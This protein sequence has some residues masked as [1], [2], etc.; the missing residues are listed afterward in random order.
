MFHVGKHRIAAVVSDWSDDY[1]TCG[2]E[3]PAAEG[4]VIINLE[5]D[6]LFLF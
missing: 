6:C 4:G 1:V 3:N 2:N 5:S